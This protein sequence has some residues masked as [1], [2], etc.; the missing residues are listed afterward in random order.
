MVRA[1]KILGPG[2]GGGAWCCRIFSAVQLLWEGS[3]AKTQ[4]STPKNLCP[5]KGNHEHPACAQSEI[6][7]FRDG[8]QSWEVTPVGLVWA[9]LGQKS[10]LHKRA[11]SLFLL[12]PQGEAK[13]CPDHGGK[14]RR[15]AMTEEMVAELLSGTLVES[16]AKAQRGAR[17]GKC[18]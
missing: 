16:K 12:L 15:A 9:L 18:L 11:H 6:C 5:Q 3:C 13:A 14:T 2:Q 10:A 4:Q 7:P 1:P 8:T 17:H